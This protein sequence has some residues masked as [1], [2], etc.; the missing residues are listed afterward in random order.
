MVMLHEFVPHFNLVKSWPRINSFTC[1][2]SIVATI[3][4]GNKL[5]QHGHNL[6]KMREQI[7]LW[8]QILHFFLLMSCVGAVLLAVNGER[9]FL[10][11]DD[12]ITVSTYWTN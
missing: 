5:V 2:N 12:S 6:T 3:Q 10:E 8:R 9:C 4:Q 1:Y 7:K 11:A